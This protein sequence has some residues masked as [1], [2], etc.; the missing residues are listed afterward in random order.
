MLVRRN[1]PSGQ[2]SS[3]FILKN[4]DGPRQRVVRK[5]MVVCE[6]NR[7]LSKTWYLKQISLD[8]VQSVESRI[9]RN[10]MMISLMRGGEMILWRKALIN[11]CGRSECIGHAHEVASQCSEICGFWF[12]LPTLK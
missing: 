11:R 9:F 8:C 2:F 7:K 3:S 12:A 5:N 1:V 10:E 6:L 4:I